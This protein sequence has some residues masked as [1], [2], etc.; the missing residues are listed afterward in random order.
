MNIV[1]PAIF[2][3]DTKACE[4]ETKVLLR[5]LGFRSKVKITVTLIVDLS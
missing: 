4:N 5:Y 1:K 2:L 3:F